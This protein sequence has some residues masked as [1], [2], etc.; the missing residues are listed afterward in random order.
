MDEKDLKTYAATFTVK[1]LDKQVE[2]YTE[3]IGL[4]LQ[5]RSPNEAG[6]GACQSNFL[7]LRKSNEIKNDALTIHLPSRR[8]LAKVVGRL[9]TLRYP[10]KVIDHGNRHATHL[11]DPEGNLIEVSVTISA[12]SGGLPK[13]QP[14][15]MEAL[16]NELDP[17][18]RLCDKMPD[19]TRVAVKPGAD[20]TRPE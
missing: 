9:C 2:F 17:D 15:D 18:D 11:T 4:Q 20:D 14:L 8:E 6:F 5:F 3:T 12:N 19:K 16:F 1:D 13:P 7:L 10:N